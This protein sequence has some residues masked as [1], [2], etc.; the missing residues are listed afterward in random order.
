M[1]FVGEVLRS[2]RTVT[3]RMNTRILSCPTNLFYVHKDESEICIGVLRKS[4]YIANLS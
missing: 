1:F 4:R 2:I 3:K